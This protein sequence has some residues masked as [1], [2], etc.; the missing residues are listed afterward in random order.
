MADLNVTADFTDVQQLQKYLE[1]LGPA[2]GKT[3][4]RLQRES[5]QLDNAFNAS[6]QVIKRAMDEVVGAKAQRELDQ[7]GAAQKRRLALMNESEKIAQRQAVAEQKVTQEI[8]RQRD[9]ADALAAANAKRFQSQIGGNLGLGAQGISASGSADAFG[10]EIERLRLKYDQIYASSQLYER[11]LNELKQAHALGITTVKQHE[12]AVESLNME[13]QQ[14][15]SGAVT[16]MNRFVA[17]QNQGRLGMNR[18]GMVMQQTGYQVGDFL[19]QVQGGTNAFVAFGQQATQLAGLMSTFGGK[20][21]PIGAALGII[22]PLATAFGAAWMRTRKDTDEAG[23]GVKELDDKLKSLD[24]TLKEWLFTKE[25]ASL[26]ITV[27]EL[28]GIRGVDQAVAQMEAAK[29]KVKELSDA[30]AAASLAGGGVADGGGFG[31]LFGSIAL[32][33]AL[34]NLAV[35]EQSYAAAVQRVGQLQTKV[36]NERLDGFRK[37]QATLKET[38][39]IE[40]ATIRFGQDSLRVKTLVAAQ[41]RRIYEEAQRAKV[42]N[43]G[44]VAI[45]M[46][47]Y[48]EGV[49]VA[50]TAK[51]WKDRTEEVK[52]VLDTINGMVLNVTLQI[53][54]NMDAAAVAAFGVGRSGAGPGGP[55]VGSGDLAELQ[56]GGGVV[57]NMPDISKGGSGGGGGGGDSGRLDSL[58]AELQTE[59]E[60]LAIWYEESQTALQSASD[61]ELAILGGKHEAMLR[62]TE[63]Y[64]KRKGEIEEMGNKWSLE[65]ALG[66]C[67]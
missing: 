59:Q 63:E 46:K 62:L 9:A 14:F 37:E 55:L 28:L 67:C 57:R 5:K 8:L 65:S 51:F 2:F 66:W 6:A 43:E 42:T 1:G 39:D 45:L 56:A 32:N 16:G 20:L 50:N 10:A 58:I 41:E 38:Q 44:L 48:D 53:R 54:T 64:I 21:L 60:T 19:V 15:Q 31:A 11:S 27:E 18:M 61:A 33:K 4:A 22:I 52:S 30:V 35:A 7:W 23:K 13:Y 12:A 17:A 29:T 24:S 47:Q 25:A 3:V 34:G 49:K 40:L 36:T 26:G